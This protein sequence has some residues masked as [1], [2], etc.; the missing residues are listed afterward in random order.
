MLLVVEEQASSLLGKS[1]KKAWPIQELNPPTAG[2][3]A[4]RGGKKGANIK[5]GNVSESLAKVHRCCL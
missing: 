5:F 2:F 1:G 3:T 4:K